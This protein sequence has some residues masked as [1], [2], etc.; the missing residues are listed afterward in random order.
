MTYI[1]DDSEVNLP[2]FSEICTFC[3]HL[4]VSGERR[5]AA[6]PQEIPLPI[7]LGENDH[8][9]PFPGDH[10]IQFTPA[11]DTLP[12]S[13][14]EKWTKARKQRLAMEAHSARNAQMRSRLWQ[15]PQVREKIAAIINAEIAKNSLGIADLNHLPSVEALW[16]DKGV[17]VKGKPHRKRAAVK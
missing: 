6:F 16:L 1:L 15:N 12:S 17:S 9:Q 2:A 13:R 14:R 3:R 8:R 5:C 11:S 7:W 10:G 4:D